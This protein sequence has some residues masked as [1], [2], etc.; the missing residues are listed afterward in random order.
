[1]SHRTMDLCKL[2]FFS[3]FSFYLLFSRLLGFFFSLFRHSFSV[4]IN[5]MHLSQFAV[6]RPT[7]MLIWD[8]FVKT[9]IPSGKDIFIFKSRNNA[10]ICKI[11]VSL[12]FPPHLAL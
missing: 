1:M 11:P 12:L 5:P 7:D 2:S 4:L 10:V 8:S 6:H 3:R 9:S